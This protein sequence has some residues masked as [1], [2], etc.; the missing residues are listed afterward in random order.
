MLTSTIWSGVFMR[1]EIDI[2]LIELPISNPNVISTDILTSLK[3]TKETGLLP[4][5]TGTEEVTKWVE[6]PRVIITKFKRIFLKVQF[7]LLI[8]TLIS[9]VLEIC[10]LQDLVLV[11]NLSTRHQDQLKILGLLFL[12]MVLEEERLQTDGSNVTEADGV[13]MLLLISESNASARLNQEKSLTDV[14]KKV[15]G[16]RVAMVSFS[17]VS[18]ERTE[19][20]WILKI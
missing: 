8:I 9:D 3:D 1:V 18:T 13:R 10:G 5:T 20:F 17:T 15:N 19:K 7:M 4:E 2:E 14:P 11:N 6:I 12:T 16:A